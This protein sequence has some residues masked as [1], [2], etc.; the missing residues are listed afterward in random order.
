M[1]NGAVLTEVEAGFQK[2]THTYTT[3]K[4]SA[5]RTHHNEQKVSLTA[6]QHGHRVRGAKRSPSLKE[7]LKFRLQ[8]QTPSFNQTNI[9]NAV[10]HF[11]DVTAK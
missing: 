2:H 4:F 5:E 10:N 11:G 6:Y 1:V 8:V 9:F 7:T 3:E